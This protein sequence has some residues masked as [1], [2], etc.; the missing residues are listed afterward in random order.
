VQRAHGLPEPVKQARFRKPDGTWGYRDR[1]YPDYGGLAIELDGKRFHPDER[2]GHD[3]DRDNTAAVSGATLRYGWTDVTQQAC[4][5]ARQEADA[6]RNRGW[7][8]DLVPCSPACRATS[9]GRPGPLPRP[10]K[11]GTAG[12]PGS[13]QLRPAHPPGHRRG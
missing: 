4:E 12:R 6:L 1:H 8:G 2:R 13:S 7:S 3:Q 5:T 11:A 9:T 10:A